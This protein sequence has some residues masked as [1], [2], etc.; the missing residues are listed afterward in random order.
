MAR[1]QERMLDRRAP[2]VAPDPTTEA[3]LVAA[4][5]AALAPSCWAEFSRKRL[6][7]AGAD[8]INQ[9]LAGEWDRIRDEIAA[10]AR[11]A[12]ELAAV[13]RRAG[14]PTTAAELGWPEAFRA[15]A[16][17]SARLIRDRYTFLDFAANCGVSGSS[18]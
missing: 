5:G 8:R 9:L 12:S 3:D 15:R 17:A 13:L 6:D 18:A 4:F 7:G 11:P 2:R 16:V 14:A 1:L 10:I